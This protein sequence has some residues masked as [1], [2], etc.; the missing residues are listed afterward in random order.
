MQLK[1]TK[2]GIVL[3]HKK[4]EN[5]SCR[6]VYNFCKTKVN[7]LTSNEN[8]KHIRYFYD[9]FKRQLE[10]H[11]KELELYKYMLRKL[12]DEGRTDKDTSIFDND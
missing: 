11:Q 3:V 1:E 5:L 4:D 6:N 9:K 10:R 2:T 12:E 7:A 8:I